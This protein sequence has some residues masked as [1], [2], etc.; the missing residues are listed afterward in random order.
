MKRLLRVTIRAYAILLLTA[1]GGLL[2]AQAAGLLAPVLMDGENK[3][4]QVR[5]WVHG[6]WV[7]GSLV[8]F[9]GAVSGKFRFLGGE[10]GRFR[11]L[12]RPS[13]PGADLPGATDRTSGSSTDAPS[14][15]RSS[16]LGA[17]GFFGFIGGACGAVLGCSLLLVWFSLTYSPFARTSWVA[18]TRVEKERVDPSRQE[19]PVMKT[20]H[21][22]ALYLVGIP[23]GMGLLAGILIGG[24]GA[25]A[26]AV[27][28]D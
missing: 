20:D 5:L 26:G 28:D 24:V 1:L 14:G 4:D 11:G 12:G 9:A 18:S 2:V 21:P 3:S 7:C 17:A 6:A 23:A 13:A 15:K 8:A 19:T 16:V 10:P 22:V 27:T 25:A